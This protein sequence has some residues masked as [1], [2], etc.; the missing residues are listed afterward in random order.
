MRTHAN[1]GDTENH[2]VDHVHLMHPTSQLGKCLP[3]RNTHVTSQK[4][5]CPPLRTHTSPTVLMVLMVLMSGERW[6]AVVSGGECQR[7]PGCNDHRLSCHY[8]PLCHIQVSN[9]R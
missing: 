9:H 4:G 3:L 8:Q 6:Q 2:T 5:K 1:A 7:I